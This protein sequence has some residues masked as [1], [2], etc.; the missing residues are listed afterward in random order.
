MSESVYLALCRTIESFAENIWLC[1]CRTTRQFML[2]GIEKASMIWWCN[3]LK[4][5]Q[6]LT[7]VRD[8]VVSLKRRYFVLIAF[9]NWLKWK[10]VF[11]TRSTQNSRVILANHLSENFRTC[12][13]SWERLCFILREIC[14][15]REFTIFCL[16]WH[17]LYSVCVS[18]IHGNLRHLFH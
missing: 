13:Y 7:H 8:V 2:G 11:L 6:R 1:V 17:Y 9:K 5:V 18:V 12:F 4:R 16:Y 14:I 15:C 3:A 10:W